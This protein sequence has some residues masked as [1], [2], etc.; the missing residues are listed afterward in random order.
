MTAAPISLFRPALLLS[1]C[2]LLSPAVFAG[3]VIS[4]FEVDYDIKRSGLTLIE[5]HRRLS[6]SA[7]GNYRFESVSRPTSALRWL[8]K[9]R[10]RETSL[11]RFAGD[12]PR[13]QVYRYERSG[14][15]K[16]KYIELV[17]DWSQHTV[18]DKRSK[19]VWSTTIPPETTDKLLYQLQLMLD[20]Q[21]GKENPGYTIA[22]DGKLRHYQYQKTGEETLTLATGVYR[23]VRLHRDD[24]RRSTTIWCAPALSYLPV[25]IEH[26]EKDGSR[27][28][29]NVTRIQGLPFSIDVQAAKQH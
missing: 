3:P 26:T 16:E 4:P 5:M 11:W 27:M 21:A 24:G 23:T 17:F 12:D 6:V 2:L 10:I 13:P 8:F 15:R 29:A 9:D 20:L 7:N 18:T 14:G 28:Q 22:D 25:R 19:P 1:F